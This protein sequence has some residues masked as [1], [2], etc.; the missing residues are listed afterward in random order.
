M[1]LDGIYQEI[2]WLSMMIVSL[3]EDNQN[4]LLSKRKPSSWNPCLFWEVYGLKHPSFKIIQNLESTPGHQFFNGVF[5]SQ[6]IAVNKKTNQWNPMGYWFSAICRGPRPHLDS[7]VCTFQALVEV[8][9]WQLSRRYLNWLVVSMPL[10]STSAVA[11]W[12][13][14]PWVAMAPGTLVL[15]LKKMGME[16]NGEKEGG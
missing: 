11:S 1:S 8:R 6:L 13:D 2:W 3:L 12:L 15:F 5:R 7:K 16:K 4:W 9:R 14:I 10:K